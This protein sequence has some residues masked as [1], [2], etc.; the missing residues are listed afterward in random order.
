MHALG[1]TRASTVSSCPD[2]VIDYTPRCLARPLTCSAHLCRRRARW[3]VS[4][5][6][7]KSA[8]SRLLRQLPGEICTATSPFTTS[9]LQWLVVTRDVGTRSLAMDP[10]CSRSLSRCM[11]QM[12]PRTSTPPE[13]TAVSRAASS[14]LLST[15]LAAS[16]RRQASSRRTSGA[17]STASC[18]Q[19]CHRRRATG[20]G[21]P[22][23]CVACRPVQLKLPPTST[24]DSA[25]T[26]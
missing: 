7:W 23:S 22:K 1:Y 6:T 19:R 3:K 24:P 2:Y 9:V 18:R 11:I 21:S 14:R 5:A 10:P 13:L 8:L 17:N 26:V 4:P 16:Q 25:M 15:R 12:R 20:T